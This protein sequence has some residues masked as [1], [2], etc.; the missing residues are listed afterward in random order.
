MK[1]FLISF[2]TTVVTM[3]LAGASAS[4]VAAQA[5]EVTSDIDVKLERDG[6]LSVTERVTVPQGST[7]HRTVPLRQAAGADADRVF[8]VENARVRGP[9]SADVGAERFTLT[10]P[11]GQSTVTYSAGGAVADT[12]EGQ[13][14]RWRVSGGWDVPVSKVETSFIA[15]RLARS[16]DCSA[17]RVG[18]DTECDQFQIGQAGGTRAVHFDL[19]PGE[20]MGL[21]V[22]LPAGTVPPNARFDESFGFGSAF[23]LTPA[24]GSGL[25]GIGLLL[26][27]GFGLLWYLRGR[28]ERVLAGEVGQVEVL[29][30]DSDGGMSFASP[31][32][33][34]PGQ[35]GTVIDEHVDVVDVTA[36]VVDLAVRNYL[37]IEELPGEEQG[38]DWRIVGVNP[39]DESLRPYEREV[40]EL[41]LGEEEQALV[42]ELRAGRE[43]DL[44]KVRDA[45]YS[46]VVEQS[47]FSRRPDTE[48]NLFWWAGVGVAVAGVVLTVALALTTSLALLGVGVVLGGI[49]LT[50]GARLMPA[51]ARRGSALV[52]QVRGLRDY[53]HRVPAGSVPARDRE[54]VF[55]RSLPY[56]VVLGETER[57]LSEFAELDPGADGTP[58][59]YWYGELVEQDGHVVPNLRRFRTHFPMLVSALDGVLAQPGH[60]RSVR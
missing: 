36:T 26:I 40:Y 42:S 51:R 12:A 24:S 59:L 2:V 49:A 37:W 50:F 52:A 38:R 1:R 21:A 60:L 6:R 30:E 13:Q 22:E 47:W 14:V 31:D 29:M 19:Q 57:W 7:A 17:G 18:T 20:R 35:I 34:L 41:L 11:P 58:G 54:M 56:A 39:P 3:L 9:G 8:T 46:D 16:I 25:V 10:L 28:D 53:L 44:A 4:A 43:V 33:V 27:G 45:L 55:S 48:R 15:P 23:A 5:G 32:G